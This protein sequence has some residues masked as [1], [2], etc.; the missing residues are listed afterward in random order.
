MSRGTVQLSAL[1]V[2]L[3]A[4]L[5][6]ACCTSTLSDD[7]QSAIYAAVARQLY[8]VDHT[9]GDDPPN[10]PTVYLV[11]NTYS[12]M[13]VDSHIDVEESV[14]KAVVAALNDLPAEFIWVES[15]DEVPIDE[16]TSGV[17]GGGAIFTLGSIELQE[18]GTVHVM[19]SLYFADLGGGGTTYIL[20]RVDG[21]WRITGRAGPSWMSQPLNMCSTERA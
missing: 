11:G 10:F 5:L 17:K 13:Q 3:T 8:T 2:A 15:R 18:D 20:E 1:T 6:T 19:A 14:Q 21:D 4:T 9:F 7:D 12:P 16:R